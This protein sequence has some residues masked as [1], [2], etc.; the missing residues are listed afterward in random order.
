MQFCLRPLA[1]R[2]A[3]VLSGSLILAC[4]PIAMAQSLDVENSVERGEASTREL[5]PPQPTGLAA[6]ALK[7][8]HGEGVVRDYAIA[9]DLYCR[10]AL[11]GDAEAAFRL[12]WMYANGRGVARD[13]RLAAGLFRIAADRSHPYARRMLAYVNR[14]DATLP[15]CMKP[16][17]MVAE[18]NG[19]MPAAWTSTAERV[20]IVEIVQKNA[21]AFGIDPRLAL[22]IIHAES[23][24]QPNAKSSKNAQGLMQLIPETA[25]RFQ[26]KKILDPRDNIRG[27]LAY[28]RWLLSF[29]EGD[30]QLVTAAYNAG[31]HAVE[32]YRGV[33][34]YAETRQ[35]VA[36]VTGLYGKPRHRFDPAVTDPSPLVAGKKGRTMAISANGN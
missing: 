21:P 1:L 3:F 4:M 7:Y 24:F 16:P 22:A 29:F 27:G 2:A 19:E 14:A 12:G 26:V 11:D 31:E 9:A 15:P 28:L 35:Y 25:E 8:E 17:V 23:A 18:G 33:P 13:D 10:A 20:R 5:P 36:R 34:P 6:E 32:R 30:I